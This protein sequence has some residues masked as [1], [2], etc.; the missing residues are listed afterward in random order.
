[1]NPPER[2]AP[3]KEARKAKISRNKTGFWVVSCNP[4]EQ[5]FPSNGNPYFSRKPHAVQ[6]HASLNPQ[7]DQPN[8]RVQCGRDAAVLRQLHV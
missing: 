7:G 8:A 6:S 3:D 5:S 1:M 4:T 2:S